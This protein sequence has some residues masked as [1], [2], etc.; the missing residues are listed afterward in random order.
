M[1]FTMPGVVSRHAGTWRFIGILDFGSDS[2]CRV[3]MQDQRCER[4]TTWRGMYLSFHPLSFSLSCQRNSLLNYHRHR[5]R[6]FV[7]RKP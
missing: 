7:A 3:A 2:H 5:R 1:Q 4:R 6:A